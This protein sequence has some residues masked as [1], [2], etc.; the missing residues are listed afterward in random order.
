M[1]ELLNMFPDYILYSSSIGKLPSDPIFTYKNIDTV[2]RQWE[3]DGE[4]Y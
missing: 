4:G 2:T 1:Y 3:Q